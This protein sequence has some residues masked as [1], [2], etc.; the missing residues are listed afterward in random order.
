MFAK[1]PF[2]RKPSFF[3][4]LTL[5]IFVLLLLLP[6]TLA[7]DNLYIF[8]WATPQPWEVEVCRELGVANTLQGYQ[9]KNEKL[10]IHDVAASIQVERTIVPYNNSFTYQYAISWFV[11][12]ATGSVPYEVRLG[13]LKT[14]KILASGTSDATK[15]ATGYSTILTDTFYNSSTLT[16]GKKSIEVPIVFVE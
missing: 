11:H 15:K 2:R 8:P 5:F 4:P 14:K 7:Y 3:S 1:S 13:N 12:P 16:Y 6:I 10:F 9:Q